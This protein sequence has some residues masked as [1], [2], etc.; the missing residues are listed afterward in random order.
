MSRIIT[1]IIIPASAV[2]WSR[3]GKNGGHVFSWSLAATRMDGARLN[4]P[5]DTKQ[6]ISET[7]FPAN[8]LAR[9]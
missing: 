2:C 5:V 7:F 9:Y 1:V 4:V 8:L 6:V 3:E